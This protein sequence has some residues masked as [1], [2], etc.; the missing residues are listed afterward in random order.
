M[1]LGGENEAQEFK[2]SFSQLDKGL[3]SLSAMLNGDTR[4]RYILALKTM[5]M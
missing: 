1:N 5:G 3:K 2:E 4:E